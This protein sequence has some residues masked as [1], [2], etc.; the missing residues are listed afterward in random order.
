MDFVRWNT[1]NTITSY[2]SWNDPTL[3]NKILRKYN[4]CH[5]HVNLGL[6]PHPT[7]PLLNEVIVFQDF[8]NMHFYV[9]DR[10]VKDNIKFSFIFP[11]LP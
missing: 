6:P 1:I 4:V 11:A 2:I 8:T 9:L 3:L 5:V 10:F 7:A